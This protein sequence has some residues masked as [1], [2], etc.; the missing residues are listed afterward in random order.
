MIKGAETNQSCEQ[1][2][3]TP[4]VWWQQPKAQESITGGTPPPIIPSDNEHDDKYM[5]DFG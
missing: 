5:V 4:S 2:S 3:G 1:T